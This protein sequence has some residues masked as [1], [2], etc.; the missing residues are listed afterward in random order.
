RRHQACFRGPD[1]PGSPEIL[2]KP[3]K[4][5]IAVERS[6]RHDHA[7]QPDARVADNGRPRNGA[8]HEPCRDASAYMLCFRG[9]DSRMRGWIIA[10]PPIKSR[11]PYR[12]KAAERDTHPPPP[13]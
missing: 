1:A 7:Q 8:M 12:A 9:I 2:G 10:K 11:R 4:V 3:R 13:D 5:D 6:Q